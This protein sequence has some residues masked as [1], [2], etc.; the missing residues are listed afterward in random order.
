MQKYIYNLDSDPNELEFPSEY[1]DELL[2][3]NTSVECLD[4]LIKYFFN[5]AYCYSSFKRNS[6]FKA[7]VI[8]SK[9]ADVLPP[10][11]CLATKTDYKPWAKDMEDDSNLEYI[12]KAYIHE[13]R[14][15]A[16]DTLGEIKA[17]STIPIISGLIKETD[18]RADSDFYLGYVT[19]YNFHVVN[20]LSKM[21]EPGINEIRRLANIPGFKYKIND[22]LTHHYAERV[23]LNDRCSDIKVSF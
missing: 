2:S 22:A 6:A 10:L 23:G 13:P 1:L 15:G 7:F 8:L 12:H 19:D 21:D 5:K 17:I 4:N 11:V 20:A 9:Y 16:I 18:P 3:K 14:K